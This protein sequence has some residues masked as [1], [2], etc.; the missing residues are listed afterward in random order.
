MID[1]FNLVVII[2]L[3]GGLIMIDKEQIAHDIT[4]ALLSDCKTPKEAVEKYY[5]EL[6]LVIQ[7]IELKNNT[8]INF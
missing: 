6:P 3:K 2:I 7:E 8:Y 5:R 1:L 4:V